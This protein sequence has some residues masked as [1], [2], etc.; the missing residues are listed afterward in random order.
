MHTKGI[1]PLVATVLLIAFVVATGGLVAAWLGNFTKEQ[2][3]LTSDQSRLQISC[4]AAKIAMK[5]LRFD[6]A[7]STLSGTIENNGFGLALGNLTLSIV[8]QNATS[9]SINLCSTSTGAVSCGVGNMSLIPAQLT[10][11]NVTIGGSNYDI[12]KLSTN[13]TTAYHTAQRGDI[14]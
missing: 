1:S 7:S 9:Q 13:C 3:Q 4:Q 11:F 2:A 14:S 6:S 8:Y 5:N 10:T 12:I